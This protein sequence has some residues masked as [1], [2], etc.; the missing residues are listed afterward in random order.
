MV[1]IKLKQEG[2]EEEIMVKALL[3]SKVIRLM[4][5]KEFVRKHKFRRTNLERVIY[6]KNIDGMLN[7]VRLIINI[8]EVELFFKGHKER[9]SIDVI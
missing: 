8:V 6:M 9:T 4:M 3:D 5:S 7:Y 2:N 1:K